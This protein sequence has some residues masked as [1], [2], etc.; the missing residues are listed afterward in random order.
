MKSQLEEYS[1][2]TLIIAIMF[3]LFG[4]VYSFLKIPQLVEVFVKFSFLMGVLTIIAL[5]ADRMNKR[6][7]EKN[8]FS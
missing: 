8:E 6:E 2:G 7:E 5:I 4:I 1:D 3:F